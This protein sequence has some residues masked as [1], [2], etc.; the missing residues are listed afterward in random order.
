MASGGGHCA[1]LGTH[2]K[3]VH[4]PLPPECLRRALELRLHVDRFATCRS[5]AQVGYFNSGLNPIIY[6]FYNR[7]F[8]RAFKRLLG[9][10]SKPMGL[11]FGR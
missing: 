5:F 8:R 6:A 1:L 7:E 4:L 3:L 9:F 10:R 11:P 2:S